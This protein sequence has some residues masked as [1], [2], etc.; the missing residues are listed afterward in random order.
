MV[1][2]VNHEL[3]DDGLNRDRR[4]RQGHV[5]RHERHRLHG[6]QQPHG[7][8]PGTTYA[9]C[10]APKWGTSR[11][12]RITRSATRLHGRRGADGSTATW[13][14]HGS[15]TQ[16]WFSFDRGKL[17]RRRHQL[18]RLGAG[19]DRASGS[20]RSDELVACGRPRS[21]H[22]ALHHGDLLERPPLHDRH[23][24]LGLQFNMKQAANLL[25]ARRGPPSQLQ[26][27][28]ST[29]ASPNECRRRTR[30]QG[31][32]AIHRRNRCRS[33]DQ[34]VTPAGSPVEKQQGGAS[35]ATASSSS[36]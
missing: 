12:G 2:R 23:W 17:A 22:E 7:H 36:R 13:R 21:E 5:V 9:D 30:S 1:A 14:S 4:I 35:A 6:R 34:V 16:R 24:H 19:Q 15:R 11:T 26:R 27:T 28:R 18:G 10:F 33:L 32:P 8:V 29:R 3:R 25:Y 31:I 20:E